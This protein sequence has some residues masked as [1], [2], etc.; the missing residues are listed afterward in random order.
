M[1][2][3]TK[4]QHVLMKSD[5]KPVSSGRQKSA[6]PPNFVHSL[7]STHMLLTAQRC[8]EEEKIAF[9]AV[10]DSYWTHACSVDIMSR[11]LRE[12]FVHLYEQ[13][14]LEELLDELRMRFPQTEFEDLPDLGDL[15]LRSVLD[16]PYFFN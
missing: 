10:H 4:M 16:S 11:R 13:P 1:Q 5:T 9:A 3:R 6:F 2:V 15:D 7:D 12:E 14:L 8:L